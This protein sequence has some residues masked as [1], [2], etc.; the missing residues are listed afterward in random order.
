MS[1]RPPPSTSTAIDLDA[2]S[3]LARVG[4][5]TEVVALERRLHDAGFTLDA[6]F[7][8]PGVAVGAWLA[9]GAPGVRDRWLDPV[10]QLV[11]GLD[12]TLGDGRTLRLHPAP[13]RSVGPDLSAL[14]IGAGTRFGRI[15]A[16]WLRVHPLGV[17]RATSAPFH[18]DRDPPVSRDEAALFEAIATG[19]VPTAV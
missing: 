4:A 7:D 5:D 8:T 18:I 19:L 14:F 16:A 2:T 13:R 17:T 1:W 15:D 3:L 12:A 11:A 10:D 6:R 9:R